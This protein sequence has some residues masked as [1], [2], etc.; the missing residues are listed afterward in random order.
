MKEIELLKQELSSIQFLKGNM[1]LP[2][3]RNS[4][5]SFFPSGSGTFNSRTNKK[6][7]LLLGQDQDN[8]TGFKKSLK[9]KSDRRE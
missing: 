9:N 2:E 3:D 7:I 5:T 6:S 1:K 8:E 4:G